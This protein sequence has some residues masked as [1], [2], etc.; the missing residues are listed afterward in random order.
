MYVQYLRAAKFETW[1][2]LYRLRNNVNFLHK[3]GKRGL[4]GSRTRDLAHPK[5]ESYH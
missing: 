1:Y 2:T 5:R 4:S 3:Y